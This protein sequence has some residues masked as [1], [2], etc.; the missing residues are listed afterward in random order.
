[1]PSKNDND[2]ISE[3]PVN[4]EDGTYG[5]TRFEEQIN[6]FDTHGIHLKI[7]MS[8]L[9][10]NVFFSSLDS[11][12][13]ST[14]FGVIAA[15]LKSFSNISWIATSYLLSR[16]AF[17]PLFGKLSDVFGRKSMVQ[18]SMLFFAAGCFYCALSKT[19]WHLVAARFITGIGAG[20]MNTMS[21]ITVTDLV[22]LSKR[23]LYQGYVSTFFFVGSI[24]GGV[25]A[26][27]FQ[28]SIGWRASFLVQVP[29][30]LLNLLVIQLFFELPK[31]QYGH[32]IQGQTTFQKLAKLDYI[33]SI[34]L[35]L[36]LL[37]LMISFSLV[38][39]HFSGNEFSITVVFLASLIALVFFFFYDLKICT[40]PILPV[41]MLF[42]KSILH[43]CIANWFLSMNVFS[44]TFY[45][46]FYWNSVMN[47]SPLQCGF[48]LIP[49]MIGSSIFSTF[50]GYVIKRTY[51]YK[52]LKYASGILTI[53]GS[54]IVFTSNRN[55]SKLFEYFVNVPL[56]SS[57]AADITTLLVAIISF[58]EQKDQALV[59][60]VQSCFKSVGST[61]GVSISSAILQVL[62]KL[63][64]KSNFEHLQDI[65]DKFSPSDINDVIH[66]ALIDPN[67]AAT[68]APVFFKNAILESYDFACHGVFVFLFIT[69]FLTLVESTRM[70][71]VQVRDKK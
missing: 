49:C 4:G 43:T 47:V 30:V 6:P 9:Y 35:V 48:R 71:C 22:P 1:M 13:V 67:Y 58:V 29:V 64:I 45:I 24:L 40:D 14:L 65:P 18:I 57:A 28:A 68:R 38:S 36:S 27:M 53:V 55:E 16:A 54:V 3:F 2:L 25:V 23:G 61:L 52:E 33:G 42:N 20:G 63:S 46:P 12:L 44:S 56:R 7:I 70:K 19:L 41:S 11:T 15:D 59:I 66:N 21:A 69:A 62:L 5:S 31:G 17:Q 37:G 10:L 51:S 34:S 50:A 60:S 8:S 39:N 26:G 32:G